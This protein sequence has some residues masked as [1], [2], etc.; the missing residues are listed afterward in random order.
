[1]KEE[2]QIAWWN[3][4][5]L[6]DMENSPNR[7]KRIKSRIKG[8]VKGWT[9]KK[10]KKK[11]FQLSKIIGLLNR[12]NGPDILGVCEIENRNVLQRLVNDLKFLGREYKIAHEEMDDGRG[13]DIGLIYDSK[14]FKMTEKFSHWIIRR[15]STRDILQVNLTIKKSNKKLIIVCNH[16]PSRKE[17]ESYTEPFRIVAADS[18]NYFIQKI[19]QIRGKKIPILVM[20]DFNDTPKNKSIVKYALG[21]SNLK[22]VV[23][24]N[25]SA[26]LYNLMTY[27]YSKKYG[28]YYHKSKPVMLDQFLASR[29][30]FIKNST[31]SIHPRSVKIENFQVMKN[32]KNRPIKFGRPS[33]K[34]LN[35]NGFSDHFPISLIIVD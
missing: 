17:G 23:N 4:E 18:L 31:L 10:L 29:G 22:R 33:N 20:G 12:N 15:N 7:E 16:W 24:D 32:K 27:L 1:M 2:Y 28:T 19:Q 35:E 8:E 11:T 30:F 6:F 34:T 26:K 13:I 9:Q 5:N 14:K 3:L 25:N 21:T